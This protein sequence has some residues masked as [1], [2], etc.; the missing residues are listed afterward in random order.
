[1]IKTLAQLFTLLEQE[2]PYPPGFKGSHFIAANK[3]GML[4]LHTWCNNKCWQTGLENG[5]LDN[6]PK[7]VATVRHMVDTWQK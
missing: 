3:N 1:M 5:D 6:L 2:F 7:L 4:I